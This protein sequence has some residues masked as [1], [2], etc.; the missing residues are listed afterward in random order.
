[1]F[2]DLALIDEEGLGRVDDR[3]EDS[4]WDLNNDDLHS[5]YL[6]ADGKQG[7]LDEQYRELAAN[8]H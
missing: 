5:V 2:L 4:D 6:N 8:R 7:G 3:S 1:M